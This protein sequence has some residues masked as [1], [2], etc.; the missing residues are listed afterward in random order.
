MFGTLGLY[1][2]AFEGRGIPPEGAELLDKVP[3]PTDFLSNKIV[4][5]WNLFPSYLILLCVCL[6][7]SR[8]SHPSNES[9]RTF[10]SIRESS[11]TSQLIC[12]SSR[13]S[14]GPINGPQVLK[15]AGQ[16]T[17]PPEHASQSA[18]PPEH[19]IQSASPAEQPSGSTS[20]QTCWPVHESSETPQPI[21]PNISA[22]PRAPRISQP[23]HG[24]LSK[25]SARP[26]ETVQTS[27][28]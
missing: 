8:T 17:S 23:I 15:H 25:N 27:D 3:V 26:Y 10:Q 20:S 4:H 12:E 24:V 21:R 6:Q 2:L 13:T 16:S 28:G 9:I 1:L 11:R 5:T 22:G 19:P 7:Q 14:H 18:S